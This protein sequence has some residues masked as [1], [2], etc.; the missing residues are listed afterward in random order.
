[1]NVSEDRPNAQKVQQS[2]YEN[3]GEHGAAEVEMISEDLDE[4]WKVSVKLSDSEAPKNA[5]N[6]EVGN[7]EDIEAGDL[8]VSNE[9]VPEVEENVADNESQMLKMGKNQKINKEL[10]IPKDEDLAKLYSCQFCSKKYKLKHDM[11]R[12]KRIHTGD[13][14][15]SCTFC[16]KSFTRKDHLDQ[17]KRTHEMVRTELKPLSCNFCSKNFSRQEHLKRH[18]RI[19]TGEKPFFCNYCGMS[20]TQKQHAKAHERIH[21]GE[22]PFVCPVCN[23]AF[24]RASKVHS[25]LK[26]AHNITGICKLS[27]L[28]PKKLLN[29]L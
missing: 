22:K 19:H 9:I 11:M 16:E 27:K 29:R 2:A 17:H 15:Y 1:L 14:L 24:I 6:E 21:T 13:R 7:E 8:K 3:E 28:Q 20:F 25:H 12:H 4:G 5:D 26:K 10:A 18:V 23:E